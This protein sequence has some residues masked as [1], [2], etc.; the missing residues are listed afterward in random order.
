M[1]KAC[2]EQGA[3]E[4]VQSS[5]ERIATVGFCKG[6]EFFRSNLWHKLADKYPALDTFL[7]C[8]G[9]DGHLFIAKVVKTGNG[10]LAFVDESGEKTEAVKHWMQ[11]PNVEEMEQDRNAKTVPLKK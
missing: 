5:L 1:R 3:N 11:I 10:H 8:R 9:E 7:L 6:A 4:N 2:A